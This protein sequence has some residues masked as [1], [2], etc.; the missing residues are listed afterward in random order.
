MDI[1]VN[2]KE[3]SLGLINSNVEEGFS[4]DLDTCAQL[5]SDVVDANKSLNQFI[6]GC[7]E[8]GNEE[9][10]IRVSPG[11]ISIENASKE[12]YEVAEI[13]LRDGIKKVIK[14]IKSRFTKQRELEK[15]SRELQKKMTLPFLEDEKGI[16]RMMEDFQ[17]R[18]IEDQEKLIDKAKAY[19]RDD[20]KIQRGKELQVLISEGRTDEALVLSGEPIKTELAL[21]EPSFR[22]TTGKASSVRMSWKYMVVDESKIRDKYM[23]PPI[24]PAPD[25]ISILRVVRKMGKDAEGE[26]GEGS[27]KVER[28]LTVA[29]LSREQG[30]ERGNA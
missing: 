24:A 26:V 4:W 27:I 8:F 20:A 18:R 5:F 23:T 12:D 15:I 28:G 16:K 11:K 1:S 30:K 7:I 17:L 9:G 22:P 3:T 6:L 29:S 13:Y 2:I 14:D 19:M 21:P 10:L 25:R